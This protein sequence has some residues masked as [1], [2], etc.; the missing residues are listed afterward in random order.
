MPKV[1]Y[2]RKRFSPAVQ[3]A[4][5]QAGEIIDTYQAEGFVLTLRQLYYQFVSRGLLENKDRNYKNLGNWISDARLAGLIDW[6]SIEDRG[7]NLRANNHWDDPEG[8]I[9]WAADGYGFNTW[10]DQPER[11][12]VWVEK[13]AL[14]GVIQIPSDEWDV[15]WFCC[16]GYVS[17][18]ELWRAAMRFKAHDRASGQTTT[19]IYLGDHDPSGMDIDRAIR[20][21]L[22]TFGVDADVERIA[23]HMHQ[24][25]EYDPPPN[26]TKLTDARAKQYVPKYGYESWE[27]DAL[28]PRVLTDLINKEIRAHVDIDLLTAA[29]DQQDA[30]RDQIRGL[31]DHLE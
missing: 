25:E 27:L 18:S 13:E 4:I 11:V 14:A 12:E 17:Q 30:E 28:E 3:A 7:R 20:D 6:Y 5:D 29:R 16:K 2:I 19:I 23:L 24:I 9:T 22:L 21:S 10:R 26:P 1:A 8:L 15:P 31:V